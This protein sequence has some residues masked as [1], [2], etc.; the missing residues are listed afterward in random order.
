[1]N[2]FSTPVS[3]KLYMWICP[4]MYGQETLLQLQRESHRG[5][6]TL[7]RE[8]VSTGLLSLLRGEHNKTA[9][10]CQLNIVFPPL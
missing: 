1:M 9:S 5:S 8:G 6:Y 4:V 3:Q 10:E 7:C 2:Y